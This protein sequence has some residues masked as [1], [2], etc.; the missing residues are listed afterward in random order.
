MTPAFHFS[1][2]NSFVEVFNA[3][4][5]ILSGIIGDICQSVPGGKSEMDV[6]PLIAKCS[7]DIICGKRSFSFNHFLIL[8]ST[9][10]NADVC[11]LE[12]AMGTTINAQTEDSEYVRAVYR[13]RKYK[14]IF[15]VLV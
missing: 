5:R 2:L 7:L 1:I 3:Q 13:Y 14:N 10:I 4:S 8:D 11:F 15:I 12:A 6:Y 9:I